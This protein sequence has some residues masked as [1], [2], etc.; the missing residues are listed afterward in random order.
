[1]LL[2]I[3]IVGCAVLNAAVRNAC[4]HGNCVHGWYSQDTGAQRAAFFLWFF[5]FPVL[6]AIV[7]A[8]TNRTSHEPS[9]PQQS[10]AQ[11]TSGSHRREPAPRAS[12]AASRQPPAVPAPAS[13]AARAH[14]SATARKGWLCSHCGKAIPKGGTYWYF[15]VGSGERTYRERFCASCRR[16]AQAE[17]LR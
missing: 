10:D 11:P 6:I 16:S 2:A 5:G 9:Q 12:P 13:P 14:S 3:Y 8:A 7:A 4:T 15:T 1:M 17:E